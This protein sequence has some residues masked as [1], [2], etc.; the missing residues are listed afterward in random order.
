MDNL[1]HSTGYAEQLVNTSYTHRIWVQ[2]TKL[3]HQVQTLAY[4]YIVVDRPL[5]LPVWY[6][7]NDFPMRLTMVHINTEQQ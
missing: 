1:I 3:A 7:D 4:T 6:Q 2:G 5:K